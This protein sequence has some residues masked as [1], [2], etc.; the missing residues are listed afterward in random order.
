MS[1]IYQFEFEFN[2][3]DILL[4]NDEIQSIFAEILALGDTE[5]HIHSD[6][7]VE[8]I[9]DLTSEIL[10]SPFNIPES[11]LKTL[12]KKLNIHKTIR[13]DT[14]KYIN[15]L[16]YTKLYQIIHH[17]L[18][19]HDKTKSINIHQIIKAIQFIHNKKIIYPVR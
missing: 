5:E 3:D 9:P 14:L 18:L 7:Y 2:M 11:R 19:H 10:N 1:D 17:V 4:S 8:K 12:L 15:H 6:L 13:S 16:I